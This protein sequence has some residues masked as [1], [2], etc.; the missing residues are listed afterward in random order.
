MGVGC[1]PEAAGDWRGR[2]EC[3]FSES[4]GDDRIPCTYFASIYVLKNV[5]IYIYIYTMCMCIHFIPY[6]YIHVCTYA[7]N[8]Y[9]CV[10]GCHHSSQQE[11]RHCHLSGPGLLASMQGGVSITQL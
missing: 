1:W 10:E 9:V 6:I 4:L 8:K 7:Y 5:S 11:D 2:D 3:G